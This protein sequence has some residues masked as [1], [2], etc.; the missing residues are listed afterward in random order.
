MTQSSLFS[1]H[2]Q[3]AQLLSPLPLAWNQGSGILSVLLFVFY[4]LSYNNKHN[5]LL[6][7]CLCCSRV[8]HVVQERIL[9]DNWSRFWCRPTN[10]A[11]TLLIGRQEG[12]LTCKNWVVRYWHGCLSGAS[13]RWSSWC[14]C[15]PMISCS[16]KIQNGLPFWC[17]HTQV[18]LEKKTI[19][20]M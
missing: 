7:V 19:K 15:H 10:N 8:G 9:G 16:S 14:H 17:Q 1:L 18:V 13:C 12:H 2:S 3:T 5:S 20:W 4:S 11:L 6:T